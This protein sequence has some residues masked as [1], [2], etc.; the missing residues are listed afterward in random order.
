LR[1]FVEHAP[2]AIAM[3][4]LRMRYLAVSRRWLADYGLTGQEILGRSHYD[5]F[6]EIPE[7]WKE[8]HRRCLAGAV[9]RAEEDPF[10]RADGSMQWIRWEARPWQ[11]APDK[12]G[13]IIIFSED[14]TAHKQ[15]ESRLRHAADELARSNKDL[16]QFAYVASHDLQEPLRQVS[17]FV[18]L[19]RDRCQ[20]KLDSSA[21]EYIKYAVDGASRMSALITD[22]LTYSRVGSKGMNPR[23]V[24]L[25]EPLDRAMALLGKAV[26]ESGAKITV[27]DLPTVDADGGQLSQVF[28]NLVGNALKFRSERPLE[29]EIGARRKTGDWVLWV[30]DNGIGLDP[31]QGSRVFE[32]FRRLHD[33]GKYPGTGIG[34]AICKK[35][36]E[37]HGGRIWVESVPGEGS[38][39]FFTIACSSGIADAP[40]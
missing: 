19:L 27:A 14:V 29:I 35:I 25:R 4:D 13:G 37:R 39:F 5:I 36:V 1:L 2:A 10:E 40:C 6:P 22:L 21:D 31:A 8:I 33:R 28:Q 38:T 32:L 15:A 11:S 16:E 18:T 7:R 20:G 30:K 9:E 17:S 23:S 24:N 26:A 34:L 12:V 3:F